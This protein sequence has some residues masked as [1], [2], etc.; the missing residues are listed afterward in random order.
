VLSGNAYDPATHRR[1]VLSA[2]ECSRFAADVAFIG[3]WE[4]E[5]EELLAWVARL[6][7]VLAIW[8]PGWASSRNPRILAAYRGDGA[9]GASYAKAICGA[10]IVLGLLSK[11]AGDTIT[12]RSVEIPACEAFMLAERTPEHQAT[13]AEGLEAEFFSDLDELAGKLKHYLAHDG[14]RTRIAS[15]GWQRCLSSGYSYPDRLKAVLESLP[16]SAN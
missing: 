3:R 5:R 2:G 15:A 13:F 11:T 1:I 4:R 6:G 16:M 7:V 10:R 9:I 14:E 8:G 12:Q